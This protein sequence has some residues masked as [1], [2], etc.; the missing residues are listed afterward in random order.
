MWLPELLLIAFVPGALL[1]R[2]PVLERERRAA[3][4]AE[5]RA[6]WAVVI[7]AAWSSIV[8][9]GLAAASRYT[10]PRLLAADALLSLVVLGTWR[11][12][13][14]YR[15]TA[16]PI[17]WTAAL[18]VSLVALGLVLFFP[19][20]EFVIG[21]K[22]PGV[23]INEGIALAHRGS[24]VVTDRLVAAVPPV[25]QDLFFPPYRDRWYFSSRFMGFFLVD[26]MKGTVV[27]QFPHLYPA[28]IAIGHG[29]D[30]IPGALRAVGG[31]AVFGLV[32]VYFAGARLFGRIPAWCASTLLALTVVE[33]WFG[34]YP[35]SEVVLQALVFAGLLAF[36]R[37]H[38][39][40]DT[41]FAPV[42]AV[43]LGLLVFVRFDAV[44]AW[45][46][47]GLGVV[48]LV[49]HGRKPR[50]G[51]LVPAAVSIA[52]AAVY[53]RAVMR[54]GFGRYAAFFETLRPVH[55]ALMAAGAAASVALLLL[56]RSRGISR[57]I[58]RWTPW[59]LS[60]IVVGAFVYAYGFRTPGGRLA[61][62]DA[63]SLRTFTWYVPWAGL[64]A[65]VAGFVLLSWRRFWRDPAFLFVTAIY[66]F[67]VFYKIQIVPEHFWMAR[68]FLPVIL[69]SAFLLMAAGAFYGTWGRRRQDPE[70]RFARIARWALPAAFVVVVGLLL[71]RAGEPVR[72]HVEYQG[73]LARIEN[74]SHQFGPRDLVVVES[75]RSSDL[76]VIALPLAYT[77]QRNVLVLGTPR[78]DRLKFRGFLDW[79]R[80]RYD[81]VYFMG[82][83][84]TDL[85]SRGVAVKPIATERFQVPE[86]QST[87][88]A[89][90]TGAR[91]KEF[92][93]SVYRFV[94][95]PDAPAPFDLRV[96]TNDDLFVVRFNAKEEINGQSH[97]WTTDSSYVTL[98]GVTEAS[99]KVVL[100]MDQGGRPA[101]AGP[102]V[103]TCYLDNRPV[104][105]ATVT[106]RGF[107]PFEFPI[108]PDLAAAAATRDDPVLLRIVTR[109]WSPRASGAEDDRTLGVM[110][111]RVAVQ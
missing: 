7:G 14:L 56:S 104:G 86:Y 66:S 60:T 50:L 51:F 26:P 111:G 19:A 10:F 23:Y 20:S 52:A 100:W 106:G 82:S 30:G 88:N 15:G 105:E 54:P 36:A 8:V 28:W 39:E 38:V 80:S 101:A 90:P 59:A 5:E 42:A 83:G 33:S 31:W 94:E 75:R 93:F 71:V 64:I 13:L 99:R 95:P 74:L 69:P 77:F 109:A 44:L 27:G 91:W 48:F 68:R 49:L 11:T 41:F 108:P 67:F 47:V 53:I 97:R 70:P 103:V 92:D 18:P 35:N 78:P 2:A 25:L 62:H 84:G 81:N 79:A 1:F 4:S 24:L 98:V 21:G 3:L 22:D 87:L 40:D 6:F 57:V 65:A 43:V 61:A 16:A 72:A 96:G 107:Q 73:L 45:T 63:L 110:V 37:S 29:L 9:L 58:S 76:H 17:G 89:Y 46:G 12:R 102:A 85:L 55:L 34:R 32:A